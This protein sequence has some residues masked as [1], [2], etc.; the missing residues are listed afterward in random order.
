[1]W[2]VGFMCDYVFEEVFYFL[3]ESFELFGFEDFG[4]DYSNIC[5]GLMLFKLLWYFNKEIL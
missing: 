5:I 4:L 2:R 3:I 1:M